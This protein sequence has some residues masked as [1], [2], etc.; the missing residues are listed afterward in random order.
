MIDSGVGLLLLVKLI[1]YLSYD[2]LENIL[3]GDKPA[4]SSKLIDDNGNMHLVGLELPEQV[5]DFLGLRHEIRRPDEALPSERGCLAKMWEQ[6][7]DIQHTTYVVY[8]SLVNGDAA[9]VVLNDA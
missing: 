1:M 8:I 9:V 3:E 6:V 4:C 2:F 7:L 5:I